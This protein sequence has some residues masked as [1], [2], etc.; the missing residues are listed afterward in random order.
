MLR[1]QDEDAERGVHFI[2]DGWG[3]KEMFNYANVH[4]ENGGRIYPI[5]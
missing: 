2:P 3:R 1:N 4:L 5:H